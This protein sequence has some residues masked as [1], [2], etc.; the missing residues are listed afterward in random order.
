MANDKCLI[1]KSLKRHLGKNYEVERLQCVRLILGDQL[2]IKH[3]WF[4]SC[5]EGTVY[6]IAEVKEEVTYVKHHIQKSCAFLAAMADFADKLKKDGHT[7]IYLD[8]DDT[9]DM[10]NFTSLIKKVCN[11]LKPD[12]FEYQAPDEYRLQAAFNTLNLGLTRISVCH[13]NHFFVDRG[14]I[15]S[16]ESDSMPKTMETFYRRMRKKE[17]ILMEND[18]P[19]GDRWNYDINN[20][21]KLTKQAE[22]KIPPPLN[23]SNNVKNVIT[24]LKRNNIETMGVEK[25]NVDLP[26]NREQAI[27]LVSYFCQHSLPYFG[28]FQDAMTS[29]MPHRETLFHS[30]LSFALNT[31]LISPREVIKA[32]LKY[33]HERKKSISLSQIE[34]FVRQILGWRE[35]TRIIYW[36]HM[37]DYKKQNFLDLHGPLPK[38]YWTGKTKMKCISEAVTQSLDQAYAHH[39]QRLMITGN[40][41]LLAG[42]NPDLVDDWYLSIYSDAVEWAQL[43][44][45]R[46]MSQYADGG[47]MATKPYISSGNYVNKM[48]DYCK[49]CFY[50]V[51]EKT[52]PNSCPFNSLY[53][54][55][56]VKHRDKL[57]KNKRLSIPYKNLA[58]MP[59]DQLKKIKMRADWLTANLNDL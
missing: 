29:T 43:P 31:K 24:R 1:R 42:V 25:V 44:N 8:L 51:K 55:F 28:T 18:K 58:N 45:T 52:T 22:K 26:I 12:T 36:Q 30:R 27:Q 9:A 53:W 34:G 2:D 47:I 21:Q 40:F 20:R 4:T 16:S 35:F 7:V 54:S 32:V 46:G 3:R 39:I 48:G 37:P 10:P 6:M 57:H 33:Y 38:F 17:N 11:Y 13:D 49:N 15:P 59:K 50:N 41:A 56:L 23:F 14:E 19:L 5:H